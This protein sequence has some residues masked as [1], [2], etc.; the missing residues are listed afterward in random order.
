MILLI[1]NMK[2]SKDYA[3]AKLIRYFTIFSL[4]SK[5]LQN[6]NKIRQTA[7]LKRFIFVEAN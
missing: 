2:V 6:C 3:G 4:F 7:H 5:N 1:I